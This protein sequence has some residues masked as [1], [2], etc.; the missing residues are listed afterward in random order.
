MQ[1][2]NLVKTM[3][4]DM[5]QSAYYTYYEYNHTCTCTHLSAFKLAHSYTRTHTRVCMYAC[6]YVCVFAYV[7]MYMQLN[8][9]LLNTVKTI[10]FDMAKSVTF[11]ILQYSGNLLPIWSTQSICYPVQS[12]SMVYPVQGI[13]SIDIFRTKIE[14]PLSEWSNFCVDSSGDIISE[15]GDSTS[16]PHQSRLRLTKSGFSAVKLFVCRLKF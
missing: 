1:L 4:L 7:C 12:T 8:M 13:H 5:T 16:L 3:L 9:T 2:S 15:I 10:L 14:R 11:V 6:M